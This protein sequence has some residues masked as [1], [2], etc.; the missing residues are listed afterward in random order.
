MY[1]LNAILSPY[2][3]GFF[4]EGQQVKKYGK[5]I[6]TGCLYVFSQFDV[7]SSSDVNMCQLLALLWTDFFS[8][9]QDGDCVLLIFYSVSV[10]AYIQY[11]WSIKRLCVN[12]SN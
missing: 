8:K 12:C 9:V 6:S 1:N 5:G 7:M 2:K 11:K 3:V 4:L 10:H